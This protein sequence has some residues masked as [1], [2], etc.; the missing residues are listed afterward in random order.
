MDINFFRGEG[1]KEEARLL[2]REGWQTEQQGRKAPEEQTSHTLITEGQKWNIKH[3]WSYNRHI[4]ILIQSDWAS[5]KAHWAKNIK[6]MSP[7]F[8]FYQWSGKW[9]VKLFLS[10]L[11]FLLGSFWQTSQLNLTLRLAK[12]YY[13]YI[14]LLKHTGIQEDLTKYFG[15]FARAFT[16]AELTRKYFLCLHKCQSMWLLQKPVF[17][18]F[19]KKH[20]GSR[21]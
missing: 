17:T 8:N 18:I 5:K 6:C 3:T 1:G 14:L 15:F 19:L 12:R 10:L 4:F 16:T 2:E 13:I 20:Q 9:L 21:T 7:N 11:L